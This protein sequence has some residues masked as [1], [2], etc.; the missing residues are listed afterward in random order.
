MNIIVTDLDQSYL[1]AIK[2]ILE[3]MREGNKEEYHKILNEKENK[4]HTPLELAIMN[5]NSAV[6]Q[7][8]IGNDSRVTNNTGGETNALHFCSR[9]RKTKFCQ[10][11]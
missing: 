9:Y 3:T 6:V 1:D 2:E 7:I 5:K 8:L 4:G 10:I 11:Q